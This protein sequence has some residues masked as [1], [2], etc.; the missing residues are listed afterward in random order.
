MHPTRSCGL[1]NAQLACVLLGPGLGACPGSPP[2]PHQSCIFASPP[3]LPHHL[4]HDGTPSTAALQSPCAC[5][6]SSSRNHRML[7]VGG[8][9]K[10]HLVPAACHGQGCHPL[11][12]V[13]QGLEHPQGWGICSLLLVSR[14][15]AATLRS[16]E[17]CKRLLQNPLHLP[18]PP[19][20]PGHGHPSLVLL[21]R[22]PPC[23]VSPLVRC[24]SHTCSGRP[25]P[26]LIPGE[27]PVAEKP[28]QCPGAERCP[29]G[30]SHQRD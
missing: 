13:A 8:D 30:C 17:R 12:Q 26:C 7:G 28:Q 16:G 9:L 19:S 15:A 27:D 25:H 18:V 3:P 29:A 22:S 6:P 23:Q 24:S 10:D 14:W 4:D 20:S 5:M 2:I 11:D 1:V 21:A